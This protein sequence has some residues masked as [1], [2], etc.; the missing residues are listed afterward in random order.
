[1]YRG[2]LGDLLDSNVAS[3][4]QQDNANDGGVAVWDVP[5]QFGPAYNPTIF[6][7]AMY[8]VAGDDYQPS[9]P[10][11]FFRFTNLATGTFDEE[12]A[13]SIYVKYINADGDEYVAEVT[14]GED[15]FIAEGQIAF[16][17]VVGL[18]LSA[19]GP[20]MPYIK[21]DNF[22]YI[23]QQSE[24]G[25]E[26]AFAVVDDGYLLTTP[27]AWVLYLNP[28]VQSASLTIQNHTTGE[29]ATLEA[30]SYNGVMTFDVSPITRAWFNSVLE[31]VSLNAIVVKDGALGVY[32]LQTKIDSSNM[33]SG[34]PYNQFVALNAVSQIGQSQDFISK[35]G[36]VLTTKQRLVYYDG[37]P[38]DYSIL[39]GAAGVVTPNG[40]TE[41]YNVSR[42]YVLSGLL[43]LWD[44]NGTPIL[45]EDGEYIYIYG[46]DI[47]EGAPI[48]IVQ[49]CVPI[50]P[51]YV[52]WINTQ[53]GVD[54]WMFEWQQTRNIGVG[55]VDVAQHYVAD[56]ATASGNQRVLMLE[57]TNRVQVGASALRK[58]DFEALRMLPLSP[59]VEWWN[60][61]TQSWV[62]LTVEEYDM[63]YG[64]RQ[65]LHDIEA[66][67][68]L[69]RLYTQF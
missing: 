6:R 48:E 69:P 8:Y 27:N 58:A 26:V 3:R 38:L 45:T 33:I 68:A 46:G 24:M 28:D 32:W 41:A 12:V 35:V 20:F 25:A 14:T 60:E 44:E 9:T 59:L 43:Q 34:A 17:R 15:E 4:W 49:R 13:E 66:T 22:Y 61:Q 39:A 37:Y 21:T 52:R 23:A 56:T 53:G 67:F 65:A 55:N 62:R 51:F 31:D 30:T 16:E 29:S 63:S 42:V 10:T 7:R 18:S 5:A 64:T 19:D 1:M 40:T 57:A 2:S 36:K 54:Y 11:N 47:T 50:A